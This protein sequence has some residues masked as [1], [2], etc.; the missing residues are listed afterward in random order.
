MSRW[1]AWVQKIRFVDW[2]FVSVIV[3][4]FGLYVCL[5]CL[6]SLCCVDFLCEPR[7]DGRRDSLEVE[8]LPEF[9]IACFWGALNYVCVEVSL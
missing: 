5:C 2:G 8:Q 3:T 9:L 4:L 7:S 6:P 1:T